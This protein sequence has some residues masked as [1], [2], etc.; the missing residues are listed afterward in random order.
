MSYLNTIQNVQM[1]DDI[2]VKEEYKMKSL[3]LAKSAHEIKNVLISIISFI[4]NS[5]ITI[6]PFAYLYDYK[7]NETKET[8]SPEYCKNFLKSLCD[9]GMQLI[10]DVNRVSKEETNRF[11]LNEEKIEKFNAIEAL[12]FC[13]KMFESRCI[14]E[15]KNI[16]IK[17]SFNIPNNKLIN[18]ISQVKFKQIIINLL[19]NSYKFTIKGYIKL[20]AEKQ[21]NKIKISIT[22]T[23]VGFNE[24]EME[25]INSPFKVIQNNQHLNKN[26][27]GLGL[28]IT[29][30]ILNSCGSELKYTSKKGVGSQFWFEIDDTNSIIDPTMI[31]NDNFKKLIC[32]INHGIKDKNQTYNTNFVSEKTDSELCNIKIMNENEL[33]QNSIK[34]FQ[35]K[36]R[37]KSSN[38]IAFSKNSEILSKNMN[39]KLFVTKNMLDIRL[40]NIANS[41]LCP[42]AFTLSSDFKSLNNTAILLNNS[43]KACKIL[44]CDDD[45]LT[46]LSTQN[47]IL[48]YFKSIDNNKNA[49]DILLAQNGIECLYIIYSNYIKEN[50]VNLLL[51]DK[52]M[53][54]IDGITTCALL[55]NIVELNDIKIYMLSAECEIKDNKIVD[56]YYEKPISNQAIKEI[57]KMLYEES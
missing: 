45:R 3:Y 47:S 35:F 55:K 41:L 17:T 36:N 6:E 20:S 25:D 51:I 22:D 27:S 18:S 28:Y 52:N 57:I 26:G 24:N 5:K 30:E 23:G 2:S 50:A 48:K 7:D 37:K 43:M 53:P 10:L 54:F 29:K 31:L 38:F 14:F 40:R 44:I 32:D 11:N 21:N 34:T 4:E 56:G 33:K 42:R 46:A 1:K 15:K 19:S 8:L 39:N 9:F 49:P 16:Q 13:V 12:N